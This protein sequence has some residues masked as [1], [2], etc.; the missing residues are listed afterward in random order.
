MSKSLRLA[1]GTLSVF[2]SAL[3]VWAQVKQNPTVW[4]D[5]ANEYAN[6]LEAAVLKKHTPMTFETNKDAAQYLATLTSEQKKGSTAKAI[7]LGYS[8]A[9]HSLSMSV[10]D[11]K[12]GA[13]VFSYTCEKHE[14]KSWQ[15]ASECLAKHWTSFIEKGKP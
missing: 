7:F 3:F 11:A 12:T 4:I 8:G 9:S 15:S 14:A 13:V 6:Y 2:A 1:L 5:P 10:S